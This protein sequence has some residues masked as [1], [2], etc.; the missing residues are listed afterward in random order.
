MRM[1]QLVNHGIKGSSLY[2]VKL[3]SYRT[4]SGFHVGGKI[5][6]GSENIRHFVDRREDRA[7]LGV[8]LSVNTF[9]NTYGRSRHFLPEI[10]VIKRH[11]RMLTTL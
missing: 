2:P 1:V 6:L 9:V 3:T 7:L 4:K 5:F 8:I 11:D 10:R